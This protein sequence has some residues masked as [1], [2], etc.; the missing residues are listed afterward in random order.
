MKRSDELLASNFSG[1]HIAQVLRSTGPVVSCVLLR[2]HKNAPDS[3]IQHAEIRNDPNHDSI[4]NG[5]QVMEELIEEI[6]ID[7]TPKKQMVSQILGGPFTFLG[8]YE[9]E[10][11]VVIV[12][13]PEEAELVDTLVD[14]SDDTSHRE[15]DVEEDHCLPVSLPLALPLNPHILQPPLHNIQV[16]GDILLMRVAV[17]EEED[18]QESVENVKDCKS[19]DQ[20][21]D[22]SS[23]NEIDMRDNTTKEIHDDVDNSELYQ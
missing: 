15:H 19:H 11:I 2:C 3:K 20:L 6:Q 18:E 17:A 14:L 1:E 16:R 8:Q 10:G 12:R 9:D 7:T 23:S 4:H 22:H 21:S 13:R 5:K